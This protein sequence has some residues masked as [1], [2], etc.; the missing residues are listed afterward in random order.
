MALWMNQ[1]PEGV[2]FAVKAVPGSSRRRLAGL[3][4]DAL[5]VNLTSPPEKGRANKELIDFLAESLGCGR[6]DIAIV[7]GA[8]NARKEVRVQNLTAEQLLQR[9]NIG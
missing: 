7:S 2:V 5:K 3:L 8:G 9:L 4:G 6:K 1:T